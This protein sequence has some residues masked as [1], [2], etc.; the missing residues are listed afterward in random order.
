MQ[1]EH[2]RA[3]GGI[4]Y[5]ERGPEPEEILFFTPCRPLK[6]HNALTLYLPSSL[7]LGV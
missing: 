1:I 7:P 6:Y 4:G 5:H 3:R 2:K